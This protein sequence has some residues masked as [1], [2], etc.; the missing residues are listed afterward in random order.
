MGFKVKSA[1]STREPAKEFKKLGYKPKKIIASDGTYRGLYDN[2]TM[3]DLK[4]LIY[5]NRPYHLRAVLL[6]RKKS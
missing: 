5:P 3:K 2:I 1:I 6:E 4:K